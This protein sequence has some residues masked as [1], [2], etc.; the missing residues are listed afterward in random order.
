MEGEGQGDLVTGDHI[1]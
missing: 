1:R